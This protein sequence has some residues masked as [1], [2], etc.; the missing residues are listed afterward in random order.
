MQVWQLLAVR[1][2]RMFVLRLKLEQ[3]LEMGMKRKL[4]RTGN[5]RCKD[6]KARISERFVSPLPSS[7]SHQ[8]H[9][10]SPYSNSGP[11]GRGRGPE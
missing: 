6:R 7:S 10:G 3:E 8:E 11:H 2:G 4:S 9:L 5:S 1:S